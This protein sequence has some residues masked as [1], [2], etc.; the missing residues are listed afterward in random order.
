P[1]E[2]LGEGDGGLQAYAF[3]VCVTDRAGNRVPFEPPAEYDPGRFELLRRYLYAVGDSL[4]AADLLGLV[5]DLLPNGKCDVN[6]IGPFSL[7]VLDGSN[8]GLPALGSYNIDIREVE[9]TWRYLAEYVRTP[10][11]FN[12]GY[13]SI[14]AP[15]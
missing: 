4:E 6:S 3:R 5:A 11:V 7:N 10:A 15:P 13:L 2:H 12:E 8:R 14:A 9:R 1:A